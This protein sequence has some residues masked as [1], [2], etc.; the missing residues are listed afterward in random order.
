MVLEVLV[1]CKCK[2]CTV[3]F[4]RTINTDKENVIK[5]EAKCPK[6]GKSNYTITT[7][8]PFEAARLAEAEGEKG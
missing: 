1:Q 7:A 4:Q 3:T 8:C 2:D 6:C 5:E